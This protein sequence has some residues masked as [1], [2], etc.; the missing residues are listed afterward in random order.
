MSDE[1]GLVGH[2]V[3]AAEDVTAIEGHGAIA[4]ALLAASSV[5]SAFAGEARAGAA[6]MD[7]IAQ[8]GSPA[9]EMAHGLHEIA[10][11]AGDAA[12]RA[13]SIGLHHLGAASVHFGGGAHGGAT[14]G[15][16]G[17]ISDF[18]S[19]HIPEV[20]AAEDDRE[21]DHDKD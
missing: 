4:A 18:F 14:S 20:L 13:A 19:R 6:V 21:D 8:P 11:G 10:H 2:V 5:K 16:T 1:R 12:S 9:A 3:G 7:A 15:S 17:S